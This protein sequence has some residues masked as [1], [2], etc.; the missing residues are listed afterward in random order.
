MNSTLIIFLY[1]LFFCL[2]VLLSRNVNKYYNLLPQIIVISFVVL[3]FTYDGLYSDWIAYRQHYSRAFEIGNTYFEKGFDFLLYI[4]NSLGSF[5]FVVLFTIFSFFL[6]LHAI[7]KYNMFSKNLYFIIIISL[8]NVFL[9]SYFG[10]IRQC[11]AVNFTF[12]SII[13][14]VQ[15]KNYKIGLIYLM[16]SILT[17]N[18][19]VVQYVIFLSTIILY[20]IYQKYTMKRFVL[21]LLLISI[22]IY[23]I[24]QLF[25][26]DFLIYMDHGRRVGNNA[27][28]TSNET[29]DIL[30]VMERLFFLALNFLTLG[31]NK[32][33][34]TIDSITIKISMLCIAGSLFY[35]ATYSLARNLA[36]RMLI[37]YR[38]LDVYVLYVG[39]NI[40]LAKLFPNLLINRIQ[41]IP[42]QIGS[43]TKISQLSLLICIG[44]CV[45]K[46][47]MTIY[48]THLFDG[49]MPY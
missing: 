27:N 47:Y 25:F 17:H 39:M 4:S 28:L 45:L 35:I 2:L 11:I 9:P 33:E 31:K 7:S 14:F 16:L 18:S 5:Y 12:L 36:G 40:L 26:T 38:H 24:M 6:L 43:R 3:F 23:F 8:F 29:K 30:I 32:K 49:N 20:K 44:Y 22:I 19:S 48:S 10:G 46:Y 37:M 1:W 34:E 41:A 21:T 13:Y 15:I 42:H